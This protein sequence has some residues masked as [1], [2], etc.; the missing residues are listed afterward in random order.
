M[1]CGLTNRAW[2]TWE[3]A[4]D[5]LDILKDYRNEIAGLI[6]ETLDPEAQPE[7][8]CVDVW[9][10]DF[11]ADDGVGLIIAL[12]DWAQGFIRATE[13]WPDAWDGAL[14]RSELLPHWEV[15]RCFAQFEQSGNADRI[16]Q[17]GAENPPRHLGGPAAAIARALRDPMPRQDY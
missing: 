17:M 3:E 15:L 9:E 2:L 11:E 12:R 10:D 14:S 16:E 7:V 13:I 6:A 8:T 5:F 4:Q 1:Y